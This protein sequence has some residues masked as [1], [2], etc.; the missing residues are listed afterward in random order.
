MGD[1]DRA[2]QYQRKSID[3]NPNNANAHY[4]IALVYK[5]LGD[6]E[7]AILHWKEYLRL[8]PTGYFSRKAKREIESMQ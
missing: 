5:E 2:Y 6:G 8:Q 1:M 3:I 7:G 4:G